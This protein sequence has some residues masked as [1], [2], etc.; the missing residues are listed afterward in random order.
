MEIKRKL[1]SHTSN[2]Q[3]DYTVY[4]LDFKGTDLQRM[5]DLVTCPQCGN[6]FYAAGLAIHLRK[7]HEYSLEESQKAYE[8]LD[9]KTHQYSTPHIDWFLV[10]AHHKHEAKKY[11]V[12]CKTKKFVNELLECSTMSHF[13]AVVESKGHPYFDTI[14]YFE[15]FLDFKIQR[16]FGTKPDEIKLQEPTEPEIK[17]EDLKTK[18]AVVPFI[19]PSTPYLQ[20]KKCF[21]VELDRQINLMGLQEQREEIM[22]TLTEYLLKTTNSG[23][24]QFTSSLV[25]G[26]LFYFMRTKGNSTFGVKHSKKTGIKQKAIFKAYRRVK[27]VLGGDSFDIRK[28]LPDFC[29]SFKVSPTTEEEMEHLLKQLVETGHLCGMMPINLLAGLLF[30]VEDRIPQP[31]ISDEYNFSTIRI[32]LYKKEVEKAI[33]KLNPQAIEMHRAYRENVMH[34]AAKARKAHTKYL[35]RKNT[36][37]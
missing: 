35:K 32:S 31:L 15:K 12:L 26:V 2:N 20:N 16:Y 19:E 37:A 25:A 27:Q 7:G 29:V 17:T 10:E 9:T 21:Y 5:G 36:E 33:K 28:A 24:G 6:L 22:A 11:I 4:A 1:Q 23:K 18:V 14:E 13:R 30:C 3:L 8:A 34:N